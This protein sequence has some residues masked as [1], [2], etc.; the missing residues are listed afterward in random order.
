M[1]IDMYEPM[2]ITAMPDSTTVIATVRNC[3]DVRQNRMSRGRYALQ[4]RPPMVV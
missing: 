2:T 3:S 1:L 4:S